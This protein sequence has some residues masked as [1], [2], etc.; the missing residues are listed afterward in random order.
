MEK[1]AI[2]PNR[3]K[4]MLKLY[5]LEPRDFIK[6]ISE[7]LVKSHVQ[8]DVFSDEIK[9]SVL[10]KVD[11]LFQKGLSFY[12]SPTALTEK[13]SH[14]IFFRKQNF[15]SDLELGDREIVNKIEDK[16]QSLSALEKLS[17]FNIKRKL[18]V[19]EITNKPAKV[20][21]EVY[22]QVIPQKVH[23]NDRDFL[24]DFI[25]KLADNNII[26]HEFV[27]T[28][29][30]K[31]KTNLDGFF[32]QPNT[33]TIKRNQKAFKKEIFTLAHELGHYLINVE[34]IDHIE[35]SQDRNAIERWCDEFAF[36]LLVNNDIKEIQTLNTD[37]LNHNNED[38]QRISST[39]HISRIAI[40]THLV[41]TDKITWSE[42]NAIKEELN[43]EYRGRQIELQKIKN[44]NKINGIK[45]NGRA[46]KAIISPLEKD[47]YINAY[48]EGVMKEHEVLAKLKETKKGIDQL[49]YEHY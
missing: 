23:S 26:V 42:Y 41:T 38:I 30:K 9:L 14:S 22:A 17:D 29:N 25:C 32:I 31:N 3:I 5:D 10:K 47:L 2:N 8:E 37:G 49:I 11:K 28:W 36:S 7:G 6:L 1:I 45:S 40:F 44:S 46:P 4:Y 39:R 21:V 35:F 33:I 27:E 18:P 16:I 12:T 15:N 20:A 13:K 34:E 48:C 24:K 43:I 19:F